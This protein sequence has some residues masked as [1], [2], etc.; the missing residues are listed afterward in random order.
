MQYGEV[1]FEVKLL[2][3]ITNR[4]YAISCL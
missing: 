4:H 3:T 1:M 2:T